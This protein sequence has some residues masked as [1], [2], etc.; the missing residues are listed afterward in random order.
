MSP[1]GDV[2]VLQAEQESLVEA[3]E[4]IKH[5]A[6]VKRCATTGREN[7]GSPTTAEQRPCQA[8]S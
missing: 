5:R 1:P 6:P 8:D 4:F 3:T 7:A 2:D